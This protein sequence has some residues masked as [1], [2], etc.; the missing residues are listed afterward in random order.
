MQNNIGNNDP[1]IG[2]IIST[3]LPSNISIAGFDFEYNYIRFKVL[4]YDPYREQ[5][6]IEMD[7]AD[8]NDGKITY[9]TKL[10]LDVLTRKI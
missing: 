1:F 8:E 2:K 10:V 9:A 5:Y 7:T 3:K 4:S 6:R